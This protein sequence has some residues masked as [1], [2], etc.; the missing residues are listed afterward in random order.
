[1]LGANRW[2]DKARLSKCHAGLVTPN[3]LTAHE[4]PVEPDGP[5]SKQVIGRYRATG[6]ARWFPAV[7]AVLWL[8]LGIV[9]YAQTNQWGDLALA[10][11]YTLLAGTAWVVPRTVIS[12]RGVRFIGRR[13]IPWSEVV[14]VA[15]PNNRWKQLPEL[16]LRDGRRKPLLELNDNQV[17]GLRSLAREQGAPIPP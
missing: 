7:F 9:Q 6:F 3:G 14:D 10:A 16:V 17:E 12:D 4:Q 15:P 11:V 8:P 2:R 1:M 5:G 13:T